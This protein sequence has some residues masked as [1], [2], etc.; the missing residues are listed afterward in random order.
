MPRRKQPPW[1]FACEFEG[2]CPHLEGLCTRWVLGQYQ[3]HYLQEN[4]HWRIRD[5][6]AEEINQLQQTVFEQTA[7]IDQLR[8]ENKRLHQRA[9]KPRKN[10]NKPDSTTTTAD[11]TQPEKKTKKRGPPQGHPPW[12]RKRPGRIDR[13]IEVDAPCTCPHC[14]EQTDASRTD[15]TSFTQEDIILRPQTVVTE[16]VHTTAWC[17]NC[18]RQVIRKLEH[19]L[20]FAPIGPNAKAAALYLRHELKLPYRKIQQA[21]S[22]LFGL[23]FVPASSLGFEKRARNN[24]IPLYQEL[25]SKMRASDL[26]HADETYWR[27]DGEN[28]FVWYAGNQDVAVFHID[29]HRSAEA[30]KVLLGERI[31]GLLVTDAYAAYNAIEVSARQSCLAHLLRKADELK[32]ELELMTE[33]EP[34]SL[35]FCVVLIKLFKFACARSI[36]PN[37]KARTKLKNRLLRALDLICEKPMGFPKAETLRK[38]LIPSAREHQQVFAFIEFNAPPTNN[39][40]ERA[41]RP[42]VIFRKVC[43]GTRSSQGSENISVFSSLTQTAKLQETSVLDLFGALLA[44]SAAEAR[45]LI[46]D[47]S[48]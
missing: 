43:L 12:T 38:R 33:P 23:D 25:I 9:F 21:M 47:D 45:D 46:F 4:E 22:T 10:R 13:T 41:L 32:K 14:Q 26:V 18:R 16:Y 42:L 8:A 3:R 19:E 30:A 15:T 20:P 29:A 28:H 48:S 37:K 36:P 6:M 17:P 7:Q 2:C 1:G 24:A 34:D 35:R 5:A 39:H 31:D 40:A 11:K 44:G 27:E